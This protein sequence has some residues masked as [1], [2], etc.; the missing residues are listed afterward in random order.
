MLIRSI[1]AEN[2]M[3]FSRLEVSGL[4]PSGLIGIEGPNESG[5]STLGEI[6]LFAFFGKTRLSV[7]SPVSSL[8]RWVAESVSVEVEFSIC[9][10][11]LPDG[12]SEPAQ[13]F[14]IFRQID[15]H[16]TNYVKVLELPGR[17]EVAQGNLRVA[18]FIARNV[19][20]DFHEFQQ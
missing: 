5:K 15:R 14:F 13:E 3:R 18:E 19:R 17:N 9:P 4:P 16:G 12:A 20:F 6:L 7:E 2:F 10:S 8:I 1:R 11:P